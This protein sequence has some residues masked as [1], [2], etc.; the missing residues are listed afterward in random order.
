MSIDSSGP[1][2]GP[3]GLTIPPPQEE[4]PVSES[5]PESEGKPEQPSAPLPY[6]QGSVVDES[7]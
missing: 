3:I 2:T 6:Y 1:V 7:V 5:V 4:A